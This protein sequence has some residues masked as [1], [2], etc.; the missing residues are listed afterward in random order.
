VRRVLLTLAAAALAGVAVLAA[1]VGGGVYDIS[2]TD[3]HLAPTYWALD[4]ASRRSVRLRA[5]GIAPPPLDDPVKVERGLALY[6]DHCARCHGG[7]GVAPEAFALGMTP[8]PANLVDTARN[9]TPAEIYWTVRHGFKMTGMPAWEFRL[10]DEDLWAV[11]AFVRTLAGLAPAEYRRRAAAAPPAPPAATAQTPADARRG[12]IAIQ[13]YAC[14]T[15]HE[16]PGIV[17]ANKPVGP[18][19]DGMARRGFIGGILANEPANMARWLRDPQAV[20]PESAMPNLGVTERDARD[21]A[22]YLYTLR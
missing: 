17:G 14:A 4:M 22:A 20:S 9:W 13:Q 21:I 2:A 7:P 15:C 10:P 8:A 3:Q 16:I 1:V 5:R 12:K 6:R 11:T 18:P 19:L